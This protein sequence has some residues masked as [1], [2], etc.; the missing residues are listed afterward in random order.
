MTQAGTARLRVEIA[1]PEGRHGEAL[2]QQAL[3]VNASQRA[4]NDEPPMLAAGARVALAE[5]TYREDLA[6]L[7]A[8]G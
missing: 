6:L 5:Q 1:S 4:D 8:N 3:A 7:P 2:Q